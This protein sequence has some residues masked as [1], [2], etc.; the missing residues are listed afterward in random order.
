MTDKLHSAH[1][2]E[3]N[4]GKE[5]PLTQKPLFHLIPKIGWMNDPNGFSYYNG[6][7]HMFYQYHPYST[8]WGPMHWGHAISSDMIKWEHVEAAMAPDSSFDEEGCFSGTALETADGKHLIIYTGVTK[9]QSENGEWYNLQNQC[10]AI[11]NGT[12]YEKYSNNPVITG[13]TLPDNF[14]KRD[15]RDPKIWAENGVLNCLVG[16]KTLEG[17]GQLAKY[18]SKDGL[19]WTF[20]KIFFKNN[21]RYGKMWECPDYFELNG[22]K[23]IVASPQ[24]IEACELFNAGYGTVCV[25]GHLDENGNYIEESFNNLDYGL[26]FYAPETVKT[27]DGRTVMIGWLQNW[28]SLVIKRE[29]FKWFGQTSLP[30]EIQL[31]NDKIIINPIKEIENYYAEKVEV[32]DKKICGA[33]KIDNVKGRT[34]DLKIELSEDSTN[35]YEEF[36]LKFACDEKHYSRIVYDRKKST[37]TLDRMH[38]GNRRSIIHERTCKVENY[39]GKLKLRLILD[40]YSS[41]LFINDGEQV[42]SMGI[43]TDIDADGIVFNCNGTVKMNLIM[44]N[45]KM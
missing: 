18:T 32:I 19:S 27:P 37:I 11:G 42:M 2:Y 24:E 34:V 33:T 31:I 45:L 43:F 39:N 7:Y 22:K 8:N 20:E 16:C 40:R 23:I 41:E 4:K 21:F 6:K 38:S 10:V 5:V 30:R 13:D 44:H 9:T 1:E 3:N 25:V 35:D 36:E 17:D 29:D 12:E 14:S 26:D 15:F 28:D